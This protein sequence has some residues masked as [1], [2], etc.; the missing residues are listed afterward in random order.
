MKRLF[1]LMALL[2]GCAIQT[3]SGMSLDD[4]TLSSNTADVTD[5]DDTVTCNM[6]LSGTPALDA[7]CRIVSPTGIHV[8]S[9]LATSDVGGVWSCPITIDA[10]MEAGTWA[11]DYVSLRTVADPATPNHITNADLVGGSLPG[12]PNE[13]SLNVTVTS[14]NADT[15]PPLISNFVALLGPVGPGG[16][17][18]CTV[19][20][21]DDSPWEDSGCTFSPSDGSKDL[22]CLGV[23]G[24]SCNFEIPQTADGGVTYT[25]VNHFARDVMRNVT[26]GNFGRSFVTGSGGGGG[27]GGG[28]GDACLTYF[29]DATATGSPGLDW[30]NS[31]VQTTAYD[32]V[33]ADFYVRSDS[34]GANNGVGLGPT[35]A[36]EWNDMPARVAMWGDGEIRAYDQGT[37][38]YRCD[39]GLGDTTCPSWT[40][41]DWY[42]VIISANID[43]DTYDV[44]VALC[45]GTLDRIAEDFAFDSDFAPWDELSYIGLW[46]SYTG[47]FE[48]DL[49][50]GSWTPTGS[51]PAGSVSVSVTGLPAD[52]TISWSISPGGYS[53]SGSFGPQAVSD[54]DYTITWADD[55]IDCLI[56]QHSPTP[57]EETLT[58]ANDAQTFDLVSQN[59]TVRT[60]RSGTVTILQDGADCGGDPGCTAF[61]TWTADAESPFSGN[62]SAGPTTGNASLPATLR[63][64]RTYIVTYQAESGYSTPTPASITAQATSQDA[65]GDYATGCAPTDCGTLEYECGTWPDG[66]GGYLPCGD[67]SGGDECDSGTCV[68]GSASPVP[69]WASY[70]TEDWE[71]TTLTP[72]QLGLDTTNWATYAAQTPTYTS[73][74]GDIHTGGPP[75]EWGICLQRG[76]YLLKCWG[77][78]DWTFNSAS[79]GKA[80]NGIALQML[81]DD[82]LIDPTDTLTDVYPSIPSDC[83]CTIDQVWEMKGR[84]QATNGETDGLSCTNPCSGSCGD[85]HYSSGGQ[86]RLNQAMTYVL[87][88][89]FPPENLRDYF[90]RKLFDKMGIPADEWYWMTGQQIYDN[91]AP[92][93]A[94]PAQTVLYPTWDSYPTTWY[95]C[96]VDGPY[97]INGQTAFGGGGWIG[98]SPKDLAKVSYLL[99]G[100]G[101]WQGEELVTGTSRVGNHLGCG[102]SDVNGWSGTSYADMLGWGRVNVSNLD[103]FW[104]SSLIDGDIVDPEPITASIVKARA[105]DGTT[106]VCA[107][108][109]GVHFDATGTTWTG[110][111]ADETDLYLHYR[112]DFN[113]SACSGDGFWNSTGASC[114]Q[115]KGFTAAHL[116]ETPGTYTPRLCVSS[117]SGG[118]DCT[119]TTVIV[120]DPDTVWP[121]T[122]TICIQNGGGF[123]GCPTGATQITSSDFDDAL[124]TFLVGSKR[125]LFRRGDTF[126]ADAAFDFNDAHVNVMIGAFG[127]GDK[128]QINATMG[129][130]VPLFANGCAGGNP[131]PEPDDGRIVDLSVNSTNAGEFFEGANPVNQLT[132]ARN[133]TTGSW[134]GDFGWYYSWRDSLSSCGATTHNDQTFL[135]ENTVPTMSGRNTSASMRRGAFMGNVLGGTTASHGVRFYGMKSNVVSHN[136]YNGPHQG[137]LHAFK[138]HASL[139]QDGSY[140]G[141]NYHSAFVGNVVM[142]RNGTGSAWIVTI[143]QQGQTEGPADVMRASNFYVADNFI[144]DGPDGTTQI[145]MRYDG[146]KGHIENNSCV[147]RFGSTDAKCINV[148]TRDTWDTPPTG[149]TNANGNQFFSTSATVNAHTVSFQHGSGNYA[150]DNVLHAP[151]AGTSDVIE[152][153]GTCAAGGCDRNFE[154]ATNPFG[155]ELD[156][157]VAQPAGPSEMKLCATLEE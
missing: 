91:E 15:T 90:Q 11:V 75:L 94:N 114:N 133:D 155:T 50:D 151:N 107:S 80:F 123:T 121:T 157:C 149:P 87:S 67:C 81:I 69:A 23:G 10:N 129:G 130:N 83:G 48:M 99:A 3:G 156:Q 109:C 128:P 72:T 16:V 142:P 104:T 92:F 103:D 62:Y 53:G 24:L 64:G 70:P 150:K 106:D 117:V 98:M 29:A 44:D 46:E 152:G 144:D 52:C 28:P 89:N 119:T 41:G 31:A 153:T 5:T 100:D 97:T 45:D 139:P 9:C 138:L 40:V 36:T 2:A 20:A 88:N 141:T 102:G 76:G 6:T 22:S 85:N 124:D 96:F 51:P 54:G 58:V 147:S 120:T 125:V 26:V 71:V 132:I 105:A 7:T 61:G 108:P 59:Y 63:D 127:T 33:V 148:S 112:W 56:P 57:G 101:W 146:D 95:G 154:F 25:E 13:A 43:T 115:D 74:G 55:D 8:A 136:Y 30:A 79:V 116:Y 66:C 140:G 60:A 135:V 111:T 35:A 122:S 39:D 49:S 12:V 78:P 145:F 21:T 65:E 4:F 34:S 84:F 17:V 37:S 18:T 86:W 93:N 27:A 73:C 19:T 126:T 143:G 68:T 113:D 134:G 118:S 32:T 77:N 131:N 47:S 42:R 38:S 110:H 14:S 82:G 137:T 1:L